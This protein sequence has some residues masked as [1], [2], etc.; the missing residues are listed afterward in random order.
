[1][2]TVLHSATATSALLVVTEHG[3]PA[4]R[5]VLPPVESGE[6][7][8]VSVFAKA[9]YWGPAFLATLFYPR[10]ARATTRRSA[11]LAVGS[12][13]AIALRRGGPVGTAR[14]AAHP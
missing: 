1:M 6:Y 8:V 11:L 10:M 3:H 5:T 12:T 7:A 13:T 2:R 14:R 4:R 9:A